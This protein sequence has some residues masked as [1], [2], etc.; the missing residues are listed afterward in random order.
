MTVTQDASLPTN[1]PFSV[2][3]N[4]HLAPSINA[5]MPDLTSR[6]IRH[7]FHSHLLHHRHHRRI[8]T[9]GLNMPDMIRKQHR[10]RTPQRYVI[11]LDCPL[12]RLLTHR[13]PSF[14][15]NG[16]PYTTCHPIYAASVPENQS[17]S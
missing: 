10:P 16:L 14:L 7:L 9:A 13:S 17:R 4:I 11:D 12:M 2:Q 1:P 3:R 8:G 6:C 15:T 5:R